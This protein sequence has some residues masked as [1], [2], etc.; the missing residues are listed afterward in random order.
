MTSYINSLGSF[1]RTKSKVPAAAQK[2]VQERL[3][4]PVK[5]I[6]G[7]YLD[8]KSIT[9]CRTLN[10]AWHAALNEESFWNQLTQ[11]DFNVTFAPNAGLTPSMEYR[12]RGVAQSNLRQGFFE[13][14]AIPNCSRFQVAAQNRVFMKRGE[15][16][17]GI[18]THT[19]GVWD[20]KLIEDEGKVFLG[21]DSAG[22]VY[23]LQKVAKDSDKSFITVWE[24]NAE[25][26]GNRIAILMEVVDLHFS[27]T[28]PL[29]YSSENRIVIVAQDSA[30]Y[31]QARA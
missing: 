12:I 31:Y 10:R 24:Y 2:T 20:K 3:P 8:L 5:H 14:E 16:S 30:R 28:S 22:R 1:F 23:Q 29:F 7:S 18:W 21:A 4:A 6:I 13:I 9:C 15:H 26:D 17:F 19:N 25:G 11:R 27:D